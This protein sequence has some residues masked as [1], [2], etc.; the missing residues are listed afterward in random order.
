MAPS[1]LVNPGPHVVAPLVTL[2][3]RTICAHHSIPF[4]SKI[5]LE[6]T[7]FLAS[8][9]K[10]PKSCVL[11][12]PLFFALDTSEFL[13]K[14]YMELCTMV[15]YWIPKVVHNAPHGAQMP[16]FS[17]P[18]VHKCHWGAADRQ[19]EQCQNYITATADACSVMGTI[20]IEKKTT[21]GYIIGVWK[22]YWTHCM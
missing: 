15:T 21:H 7:S 3:L 5:C 10:T 22:I 6:N 19:T 2:I 1:V 9:C 4:F 20:H 14:T 8:Y 12:I 13:K 16:L 11:W 17:Y 18:M